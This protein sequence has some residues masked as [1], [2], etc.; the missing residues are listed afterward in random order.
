MQVMAEASECG[1]AMWVGRGVAR[2]CQSAGEAAAEV[3]RGGWRQ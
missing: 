3:D 2:A 1:E